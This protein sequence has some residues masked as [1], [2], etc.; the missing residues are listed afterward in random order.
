MVNPVNHGKN[1]DT[2]ETYKT[3]P[4]VIAADV[5]AEPLHKGRGG[6]TWYTGSS[7]WMYQLIIEWF[8]GLHRRREKLYLKPCLPADWPSVKIKY[9]YLETTYH[10]VIIQNSNEQKGFV[11][12]GQKPGENFVSMVD[13]RNDHHVKFYV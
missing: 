6:W 2:I 9:R 5:Y 1:A 10:I 12:D 3:E 11:A 7:G 8:F 13:D 4:Y